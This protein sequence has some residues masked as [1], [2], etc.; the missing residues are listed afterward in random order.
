MWA[1]QRRRE[2]DRHNEWEKIIEIYN[3][4]FSSRKSILKGKQAILNFSLCSHVDL[5]ITEIMLHIVFLVLPAC[6]CV[7]VEVAI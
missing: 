4:F 2:I 3:T 6:A 1:E 7:A 5:H